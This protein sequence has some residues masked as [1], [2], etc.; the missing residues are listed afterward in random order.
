MRL[1]ISLEFQD[2]DGQQSQWGGLATNATRG[3]DKYGNNEGRGGPGGIPQPVARKSVWW[4][5]GRSASLL[6][7][8]RV[9]YSSLLNNLLVEGD[10]L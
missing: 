7:L 6:G 3:G 10:R 4:Q 2:A 1:A 9:Q 5:G 8:S